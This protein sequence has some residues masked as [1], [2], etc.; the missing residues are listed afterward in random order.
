MVYVCITF[1]VDCCKTVSVIKFRGGEVNYLNSD[2]TWHT[3][4]TMEAYDETPVS[5]HKFLPIVSL[6]DQDD[7]FTPWGSTL[8]DAQGNYYYTSFSAAGYVLPYLFV[9]ILHL[10]ID[11]ASL[12]IFNVF[13]FCISVAL[14]LFWLNCVYYK[15]SNKNVML[16]VGAL[17]Y[18]FSPELFQGMGIVYW[19]QSVVQ[20][21]LLLQV[22]AYYKWKSV[23][24]N[25]AKTLFL[26]MTVLNPYIEWTGYVA[27]VGFAISELI[28]YWRS[29]F[30]K[31]WKNAIGMGILTTV[32]FA[33]FTIHYL[34]VVSASDFFLGLKNRFFARNFAST[35]S[36]TDVFAGHL[37]SFLLL[38]LLLF[39]LVV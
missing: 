39:V 5:I 36:L 21:T 26:V 37:K 30:K 16:V 32:S 15:N 4:L 35:I 12:Y 2:A 22:V 20:V 23:G 33:L 3:L 29:D 14:W 18:I 6:G 27:N 34:S 17:T 38:W 28:M 8:P 31:A 24:S 19:H 11:E 7:K 9:K 13:L 10:P 25:S 1:N